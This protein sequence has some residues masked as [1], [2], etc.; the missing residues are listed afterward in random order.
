MPTS[1]SHTTPLSWLSTLASVGSAR[2]KRK[3]EAVDYACASWVI[4]PLIPAL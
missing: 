3:A 1:K 4:W 2:R